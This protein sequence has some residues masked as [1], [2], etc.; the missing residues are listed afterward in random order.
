MPFALAARRVLY[1][2]PPRLHWRGLRL[3]AAVSITRLFFEEYLRIVF[4][5]VFN[6]D[7]L[8]KASSVKVTMRPVAALGVWCPQR[9]DLEIGGNR[10]PLVFSY[11]NVYRR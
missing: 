9:I 3:E 1:P 4:N 10:H 5:I 8:A 7:L 6:S 11:E 2:S